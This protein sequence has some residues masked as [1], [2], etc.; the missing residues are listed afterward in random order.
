MHH[1]V[2]SPWYTRS[3]LISRYDDATLRTCYKHMF[4]D[5]LALDC[6]ACTYAN[7]LI[8]NNTNYFT[9]IAKVKPFSNQFI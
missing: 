6:H 2:N 8:F 3:Q 7:I 5:S 9:S 1:L 4:K